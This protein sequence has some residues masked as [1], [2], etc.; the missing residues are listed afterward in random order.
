MTSYPIFPALSVGQD[1]RFFTEEREN[2]ALPAVKAEGGYEF[3]RP[4]FTRRPRR[5][6]GTGF[7]GMSSADKATLEAFWDDRKGSSAP[8]Y[9]T[10]P[11]SGEAILVRFAPGAK[12]QFKYARYQKTLDGQ[13]DHR[14]DIEQIALKEV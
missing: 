5:M 4:R 13:D 10:N 6:F 2:P 3:T 12:L 1:Q 14:F 8:F 11:T 9:W 7:S